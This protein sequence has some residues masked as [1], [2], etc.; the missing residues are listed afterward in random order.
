MKKDGRGHGEG[1]GG[2]EGKGKG[3]E[4]SGGRGLD[5]HWVLASRDPLGTKMRL[6]LF[7]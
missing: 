1:E 6:F 2:R 3:K 7:D 5:K 4:A